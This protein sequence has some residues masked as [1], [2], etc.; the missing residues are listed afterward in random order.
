M[1]AVESTEE[2]AVEALKL[3]VEAYVRTRD[4]KTAIERAL[5]DFV[6]AGD[7]SAEAPRLVGES[8]A[9]DA[10]RQ[11]IAVVAP[12]P[13]TVLISGETGTGKELV[14]QLIHHESQRW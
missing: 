9:I 12:A 1:V 14:A 8:D 7:S 3:R 4:G 6:G 10:L 13:S 5:C 11:E 2:L